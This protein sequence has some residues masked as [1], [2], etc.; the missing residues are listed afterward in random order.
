[1]TVGIEIDGHYYRK[2]TPDIGDQLAYGALGDILAVSLRRT[3]KS[4]YVVCCICMYD[5]FTSTFS[6][7]YCAFKEMERIY[8]EMS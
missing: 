5:T 4:V 2:Q 1:M 6:S 7:F 8:K 3:S